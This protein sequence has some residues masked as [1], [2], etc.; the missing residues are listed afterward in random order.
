MTIREQLRLARLAQGVHLE[1]LRR[2]SR[3]GCS[4]DSICR[5]LA[6]KQVLSIE[7]AEQLA[8]GLD[9]A[10]TCAPRRVRRAA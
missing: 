3:I 2:K 5:K 9:L 10:I 6:G 7:E 4:A 8:K 1:E